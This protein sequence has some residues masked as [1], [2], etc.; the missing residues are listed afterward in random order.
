MGRP[1]SLP[2]P[3]WGR[4]AT[5]LNTLIYVF[6]RQTLNGHA[7]WTA[8]LQANK[9]DP[10]IRPLPLVLTLTSHASACCSF[11]E[12]KL[13]LREAQH[14][15]K[16]GQALLPASPVLAASR[17]VGTRVSQTLGDKRGPTETI[18]PLSDRVTGKGQPL[19]DTAL[20]THML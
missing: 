2:V 13:R 7:H 3:W 1:P 12:R 18:R 19:W 11:T 15:H 8:T 14:L 5:P 10:K 9:E 6:L 17:C 4:N 20:L 16:A